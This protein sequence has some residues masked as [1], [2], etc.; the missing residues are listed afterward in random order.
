M[1]RMAQ[2]WQDFL[3]A[4]D[5]FEYSPWFPNPI[6]AGRDMAIAGY[7]ETMERLP[8]QGIGVWLE[9]TRDWVAMS[10]YFDMSCITMPLLLA[11]LLTIL[12]LFLNWAIFKVRQILL[13]LFGIVFRRHFSMVFLSQPNE[14]L[15]F[16]FLVE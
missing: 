15:R 9:Q 2:L 13:L 11:V 4:P 1:C 5:Y 3:D 10:V 16:V 14:R 7:K 8:W 6:I 12:R